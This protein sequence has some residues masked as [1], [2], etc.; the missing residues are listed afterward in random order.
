MLQS[1]DVRSNGG[2]R[3]VVDTCVQWSE[4]QGA[5]ATGWAEGAGRRV[6]GVTGVAWMV[7]ELATVGLAAADVAGVAGATLQAAT[8]KAIET[9]MASGQ[10]AE[11]HFLEALFSVIPIPRLHF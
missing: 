9:P 11:N 6:A 7:G 1:G 10:T 3:D 5:L 4:V 2:L 8:V